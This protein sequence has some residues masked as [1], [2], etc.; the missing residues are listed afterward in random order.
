[1]L[2]DSQLGDVLGRYPELAAG[3]PAHL[4]EVLRIAVR[5]LEAEAAQPRPVPELPAD[6]PEWER[7]YWRHRSEGNT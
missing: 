7:D 6:A 5:V 1:V 2:S 4:D 3:V